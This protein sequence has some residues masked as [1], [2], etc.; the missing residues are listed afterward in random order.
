VCMCVNPNP[1]P[2]LSHLTK[3]ILFLLKQIRV[4]TSA[5]RFMAASC[6]ARLCASPGAS[7]AQ[8]MAA[9]WSSRLALATESGDSV[10]SL[11]FDINCAESP[12]GF[13]CHGFGFNHI[14][15]GVVI[16]RPCDPF[17]FG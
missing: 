16:V 17:L 5:Y 1:T 8:L 12:G 9:R 14:L 3:K 2:S 11:R 13:V 10:G 15:K 6:R 7:P 4:I